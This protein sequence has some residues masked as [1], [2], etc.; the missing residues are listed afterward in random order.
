MKI[1]SA[2][3]LFFMSSLSAAT[4]S[5]QRCPQPVE[6]KKSYDP[7]GWSFDLGGQYT[8]MHF[9]TPP[10]YT[11]S[12]GGALGKVT[13][14]NPWNLFGQFRTVYNT[15][16]LSSSVNDS[17]DYEWYNEGVIGYCFPLCCHWTLTPYAG[18]GL[19]CLQDNHTSYGSTSAIQLKYRIYYAMAGIDT[20]YSWEKWYLGLQV[21]C[22][23]TFSQYLSIGGLP[24]SAWTLTQKVSWAARLPVGCK[25][26]DKIWLELTPYYRLLKIGSSNVL[27]LPKRDLTEW[28]G[29]VSFRFYL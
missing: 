9:T 22:M 4:K 24:G 28:G 13:Y 17:K 20:R 27:A 11:G 14:Q 19:D 1:F 16:R 10:T 6:C 15:G 3:L 5:P 25:L 18:V 23:P 29:F 2:L 7:K 12:T 21:D 8:W 26:A